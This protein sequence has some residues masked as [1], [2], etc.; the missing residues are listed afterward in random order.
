MTEK[1]IKKINISKRLS[2]FLMSVLLVLFM[3]IHTTG[4]FAAT[5]SPA[6]ISTSPTGSDVSNSSIVP[7]ANPSGSPLPSLSPSPSPSPSP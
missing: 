5:A 2:L 4:V 7:E 6:Q 3:F 1:S